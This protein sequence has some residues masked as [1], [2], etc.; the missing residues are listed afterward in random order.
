[1]DVDKIFWRQ[2]LCGVWGGWRRGDWLSRRASHPPPRGGASGCGHLGLSLVWNNAASVVSSE[3]YGYRPCTRAPDLVRLNTEVKISKK[4]TAFG[5]VSTLSSVA[6]TSVLPPR[7]GMDLGS[8]S[9]F[10]W[11]NGVYSETEYHPFLSLGGGMLLVDNPFVAGVIVRR[12]DPLA[13]RS[14]IMAPGRTSEEILV[15][16]LETVFVGP[17]SLTGRV[18]LRRTRGDGAPKEWVP[19][20]TLYANPTFMVLDVCKK[21]VPALGDGS[22]GQG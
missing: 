2:V 10:V 4:S 9:P 19:D 13:A 1:V 14:D 7:G 3:L 21:K 6:F 17:L 5:R 8:V 12:C 16:G 22:L 20:H 15:P 18:P 11:E